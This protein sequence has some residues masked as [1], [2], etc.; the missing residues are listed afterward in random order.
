MSLNNRRY[1]LRQ[2]G[3]TIVEV[4]IVLAVLGLAIGISYST[5]SRSLLLARAAQENIRATQLL[6]SQVERLRLLSANTDPTYPNKYIFGPTH[7]TFCIDDTNLIVDNVAN[8]PCHDSSSIYD[9]V[10]TD[11][12]NVGSDPRCTNPTNHTT[13]GTFILTAR[14]DNV[15]GDGKDS[16]TTTYR[17]HK[18]L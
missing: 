18:S 2:R 8:P 4:M 1:Q 13:D 12:A 7:T 11:C 15:Q 17:L 5:A 16:V 10:I 9:V 3:D 14:W 6:Q